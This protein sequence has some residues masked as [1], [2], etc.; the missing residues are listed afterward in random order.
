M[1][2]HFDRLAIAFSG[3]Q[4]STRNRPDGGILFEIKDGGGRKITRAISYLQLHNALQME[5][6]ISS[7]RRDLAVLPEEAPAIAALQSQQR[8][9][10]PT[11]V[12]R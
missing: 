11:Y 5:W 10:M 12:S 4:T 3:F 6:L 1:K 7:I 9:D 2:N 8:F